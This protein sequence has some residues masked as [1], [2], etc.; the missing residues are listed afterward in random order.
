M[1]GLASLLLLLILFLHQL[2]VATIQLCGHRT[3]SNS[4]GVEDYFRRKETK[5]NILIWTYYIHTITVT[6]RIIVPQTKKRVSNR[7]INLHIIH[8]VCTGSMSIIFSSILTTIKKMSNKKGGLR[9]RA[10]PKEEKKR[11][12]SRHLSMTKYHDSW[13]PVPNE[14]S[15]MSRFVSRFVIF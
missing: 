12:D 2:P 7:D 9:L 13:Y 10:V 4:S 1:A 15:D 8:Q 5:Q 3:G 14:N 11:H 6:N